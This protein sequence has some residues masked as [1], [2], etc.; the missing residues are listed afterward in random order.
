MKIIVTMKPVADPDNS[1]SVQ[2]SKD[3]T[4]LDLSRLEIKPN[5]FDEYAIEVA[6]RI[7]ETNRGSGDLRGE[8][9]IVTLGDTSAAKQIRQV[10]AMGADRG[11]LI[12]TNDENIDALITARAIKEIVNI[13]Q[14]QLLIM[15]KQTVDGDN[16]AVA[17]MTATL[18][19]WP[20]A[21]NCGKIT[22][23]SD[24]NKA[25]LLREADN[26]V[27][28]YNIEFPAVIT[29]DLRAVLKNSV[30]NNVSID[31]EYQDGP[32]FASLRN[33]MKAKKKSINVK[34]LSE[35]GITDNSSLKTIGYFKKENTKQTQYF[36]N[37][38]EL[39]LKLKE[40]LNI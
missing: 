32:R 11:I 19:N 34:S 12:E 30:N 7:L 35:L 20:L 17:Q 3:G 2:I 1:D 13:E 9:I 18:L 8:I 22:I 39:I 16:N 5:P 40:N 6:L 29:V 31:G 27:A 25:T 15:G 10:L 37:S 28:Q 21:T 33:V 38:K 14:P 4:T 26:G 24:L 36:E 23:N